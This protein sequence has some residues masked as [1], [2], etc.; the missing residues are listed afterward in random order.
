MRGVNSEAVLRTLLSRGLVEPVGRRETVGHP[1]EYGTTFLFLE[2]FGLSGLD[3]LPPIEALVAGVP[4]DAADAAVAGD[5]AAER[6][7]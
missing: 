6:D 2:Y 5:A 4:S 3:E 7:A 1:I